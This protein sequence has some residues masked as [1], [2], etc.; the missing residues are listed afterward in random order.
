[1]GLLVDLYSA[2][3]GCVPEES[4][5]E[6]LYARL[7]SKLALLPSMDWSGDVL[8]SVYRERGAPAL[9]PG[10]ALAMAPVP[11]PRSQAL[12]LL[13]PLLSLLL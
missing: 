6:V 12:T 13:S 3:C 2:F 9:C 5:G 7:P 10:Q 4:L 11:S 8:S 1:M